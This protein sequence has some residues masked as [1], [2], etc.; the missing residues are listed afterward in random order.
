MFRSRP[1][2]EKRGIDLGIKNIAT[3]AFPDEYVL[4]LG[5]SVNQY[6]HYFTQVE[7]DTGDEAGPSETS[8]W[9]QQK[10][11]DHEMH[12]YHTLTTVIIEE[13]IE[14]GVGTLAVSWPEDVRESDWRED[15]EQEVALVGV[16][17]NLSVPGVQR[18]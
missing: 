4:Y 11:T 15:R 6:K 1:P 3:I 10:L 8:E 16:R 12:F 17:P 2:T 9:A 5:N 7:Y 13:C 18:G 14:R